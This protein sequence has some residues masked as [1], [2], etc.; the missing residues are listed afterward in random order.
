[1]EIWHWWVIAGI[2]FWVLEIFTPSFV[3]G[4]VGLGCFAAAV[5]SAV[6]AS[7]TWQIVAFAAMNLVGFVLVRPFF[8]RYLD[9]NSEATKMGVEGY[10]GRRAQVVEPIDSAQSGRVRLGGEVWKAASDTGEAI[11]EGAWVRVVRMESLTLYVTEE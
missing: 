7:A 6:G 3:A 5:A 4:N 1:V 2:V 11:A 9:R 10:L 8:I